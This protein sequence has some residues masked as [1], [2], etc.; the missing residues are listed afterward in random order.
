MVDSVQQKRAGGQ[1][2]AI[3]REQPGTLINRQRLMGI[4]KLITEPAALSLM[5]SFMAKLFSALDGGTRFDKVNALYYEIW[6]HQY[7]DAINVSEQFVDEMLAMLLHNAVLLD[8]SNPYWLRTNADYWYAKGDF[9]KALQHYV[10]CAALCSRFFTNPLNHRAWSMPD[11]NKAESTYTRMIR[12]C[13]ALQCHT[14]EA[15]LQQMLPSPDYVAA[16]KCFEAKISMDAASSLFGLI[17]DCNLF[18]YLINVLDKRNHLG[19][20]NDAMLNLS[21]QEINSHNDSNFRCL[22]EDRRRRQ[23]W[24]Y[25]AARHL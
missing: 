23:L 14:E 3:Y 21:Q 1:S 17:W 2:I 7:T 15:L 10:E 8:P 25:L 12:C 22:A 6:P 4:L 5:I 18:E 11:E 16:M 24:H 13:S 19:K 9:A 20:L